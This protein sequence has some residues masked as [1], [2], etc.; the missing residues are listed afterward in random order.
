[1]LSVGSFVGNANE[2][3]VTCVL[4]PTPVVQLGAVLAVSFDLS[5]MYFRIAGKHVNRR[6]HFLLFVFAHYF[7]YNSPL[8]IS[9]LLKSHAW[10]R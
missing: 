8:E 3:L 2:T 10:W 4:T 7:F 9:R 1:M 6:P 5:F